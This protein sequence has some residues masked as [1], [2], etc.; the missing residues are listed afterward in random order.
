MRADPKNRASRISPKLH[1]LHPTVFLRKLEAQT[2]SRYQVH[3]KMLA[4]NASVRLVM[5]DNAYLV[6]VKIE[7]SGDRPR[8]LSTC[9]WSIE[10]KLERHLAI[11]E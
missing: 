6:G 5:P 2:H 10:V 4:I 8:D 7:Y 11:T 9:F 3:P 1:I